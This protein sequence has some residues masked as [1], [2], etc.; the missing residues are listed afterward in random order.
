[1]HR[2]S[3]ERLLVIIMLVG[4]SSVNDNCTLRLDRLS[5]NE[6]SSWARASLISV[7]FRA[8]ACP[9]ACSR[10]ANCQ[11]TCFVASPRE[12]VH[13]TFAALLPTFS[14]SSYQYLLYNNSLSVKN[15][16][17]RSWPSHQSQPGSPRDSLQLYLSK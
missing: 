10:Q 15:L 14:C 5:Y 3:A 6:K 11:L 17:R 13:F 2:T 7:S 9:T 1:M 16:D 8:V 12:E 4:K